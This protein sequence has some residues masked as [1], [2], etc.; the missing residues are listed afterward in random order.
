MATEAPAIFDAVSTSAKQICT[1]L[2]CVQITSL[3]QFHLSRDGIKV[4]AEDK[5]TMQGTLDRVTAP[6]CG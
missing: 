6:A 2:R 5:K 4:V 3:A 1:L